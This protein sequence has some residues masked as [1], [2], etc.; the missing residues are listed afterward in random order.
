MWHIAVLCADCASSGTSK[1]GT[2]ISSKEFI[3]RIIGLQPTT[4]YSKDV[5][6]V[7]DNESE[8]LELFQSHRIMDSPSSNFKVLGS[9]KIN[10]T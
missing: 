4:V 3:L 5:L 9:I 2:S 6:R 7:T 1:F 10:H 8:P